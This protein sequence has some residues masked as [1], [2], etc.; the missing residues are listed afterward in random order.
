MAT[1]T[2][3][4]A[5]LVR[6]EQIDYRSFVPARDTP[7]TLRDALTD[8]DDMATIAAVVRWETLMRLGVSTP[9]RLLESWRRH[10]ASIARDAASWDP[11]EYENTLDIRSHLQRFAG[12]LSWAGQAQWREH[13]EP[14]D[15]IFRTCT[16]RRAAPLALAGAREALPAEW[17]RYR[18]PIGFSAEDRDLLASDVKPDRYVSAPTRFSDRAALRTISHVWELA[19]RRDGLRAM[20]DQEL[21]YWAKLCARQA[22]AEE[23]STPPGSWH[24]LDG[25]ARREQQRRLGDAGSARA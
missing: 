6:A 14:A 5:A 18:H 9:D 7:M 11:S 16:E 17:W 1:A 15:K 21:A 12:V 4:L 2:V 13:I 3:L 22:R 25:A 10:V 24:Q 20:T 23:A 8:P 19:H